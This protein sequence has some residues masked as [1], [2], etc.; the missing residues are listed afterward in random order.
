MTD[1][2]TNAERLLREAAGGVDYPSGYTFQDSRYI[3]AADAL[4]AE[5]ERRG[6]TRQQVVDV[7]ERYRRM[8]RDGAETN[9]IT[10]VGQSV[11]E[12]FD[13]APPLP[14]A[15]SVCECGDPSAT[16]CASCIVADYQAQHPSCV[17]CCP[18]PARPTPEDTPDD[19]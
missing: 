5:R 6:P 11:L 19:R 7:L 1:A 4:A 13:A 16:S 15:P 9:A 3:A 14:P 12:L 2:L 10:A 18:L 17:T 8:A